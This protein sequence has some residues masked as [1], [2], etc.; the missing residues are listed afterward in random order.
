MTINESLNKV[1]DI[2]MSYASDLQK[3]SKKVEDESTSKSMIEESK[4][5]IKATHKLREFIS[6]SID[7]GK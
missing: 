5:I 4:Q 3:E 1:Q 7:D 2:C 6:N